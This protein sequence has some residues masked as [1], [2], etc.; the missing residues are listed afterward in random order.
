MTPE[1]AAAICRGSVGQ[2]LKFC[3]LGSS[4]CTFSTHSKKIDVFPGHLYISGPRNTAYAG[5]TLDSKLLAADQLTATL[6]ERH[7]KED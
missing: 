6:Q 3:T 5:H 2:G 7:T 1:F 4:Q